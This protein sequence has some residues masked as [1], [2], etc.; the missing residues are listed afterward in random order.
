MKLSEYYNI[1]RNKVMIKKVQGK[2]YLSDIS[3]ISMNCI[4]GTFYHDMNCKFL[5]PTVNLF[6][7]A[8]DFIKFVNDLDYYL[9]FTPVVEM[10]EKYPIGTLDDIK[11]FFMH[12]DS[13]EDAL[14]KWEDRKKRVNPKKIFVIMVEQNGFSKE[15]FESFKKIKYPKI[16]FV[17]NKVYECEDSVYFSQ[18][19]NCEYLP[20]IIQGRR[21]YKDGILIK[22][23]RKAFE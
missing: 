8:S 12:Y 3:L 1:I 13:C 9:S 20:D 22:A 11:I 17:N 2:V 21:Y 14:Q 6:F 23:I 15:D 18:Y 4:G 5:T 7:T 16:L 10:G 19:E